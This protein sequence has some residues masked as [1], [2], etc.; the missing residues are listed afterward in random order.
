MLIVRRH[1]SSTSEYVLI[2]IPKGG[3]LRKVEVWEATCAA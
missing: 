2:Y 3:P 1:A